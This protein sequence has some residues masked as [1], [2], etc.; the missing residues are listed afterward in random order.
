MIQ[1]LAIIKVADFDALERFEREAALIMRDYGGSIVSAFKTARN[2][3]GTGEEVHCLEFPDENALGRYRKDPRY[4]RLDG[5]RQMAIA[6]TE[7]RIGI[8]EKSYA[9]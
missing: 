4:L 6:A 1:M 8:R 2:P 9:Q 7:V 5:L 3:G